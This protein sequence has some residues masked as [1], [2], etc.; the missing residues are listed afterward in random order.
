MD[1]CSPTPC[2]DCNPARKACVLGG[3]PAI[4][5]LCSPAHRKSASR[6]AQF[7]IDENRAMR[8]SRQAPQSWTYAWLWKLRRRCDG[9][10]AR[11]HQHRRRKPRCA[12][13]HHTR[14]NRLKNV[15]RQS[16]HH[17]CCCCEIPEGDATGLPGNTRTWCDW[18]PEPNATKLKLTRSDATRSTLRPKCP[19]SQPKKSK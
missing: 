18:V 15:V 7:S 8:S 19:Q 14:N 5:K 13:N 11:H 2:P 3:L 10:V 16:S 4:R 17:T 6:Q 9:K 1:G 12:T